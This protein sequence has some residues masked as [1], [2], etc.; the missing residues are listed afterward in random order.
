MTAS[1]HTAAPSAITVII[2]GL[3]GRCPH[4]GQGKLLRRYLS[5]N[6]ACGSCGEDF[7]RLRADDGPAWLTILIVGHL[8]VPLLLSMLQA[9]ML[10]NNWALPSIIALTIVA[11]LTLLPV[12]K[13]VFMAALWLIKKS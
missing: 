3:R 8:S 11:S 9:G 12:S 7:E 1:D 13:G 2:R 10:D 5:A 4:C 6:E